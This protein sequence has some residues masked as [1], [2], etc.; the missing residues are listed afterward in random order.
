MKIVLTAV[1]ALVLSMAARHPVATM[2]PVS[3]V[4]TIKALQ[5]SPARITAN[6]GDTIVWKNAD[7]FSH[8]A[9]AAGTFDTKEM[10]P[11]ASG[12]WVV[13]KRGVFNYACLFHATMKGVIDVK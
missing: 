6:V 3:R 7:A 12:K 13:K 1:T 11:K 4:V 5:F 2:R 8:T 9:T 10:K